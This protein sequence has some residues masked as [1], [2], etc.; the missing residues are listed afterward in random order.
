MSEAKVR[1]NALLQE[2]LAPS[3]DRIVTIL[4]DLGIGG[5]ASAAFCALVRLPQATAGELVSKTGI[6]DSKIY[7]A[8]GELAEKGLIEVQP[9][10]PKSYR[11]VPPKEVEVQLARLIEAEYDRRKAATVRVAAL[12]EP[13]RAATESPSAE[14]AYILKGLTNVVS[15]AKALI[16]SARKDIVLLASDESVFRQLEDELQRVARRRVRLRIAIPEIAI[17]PDLAEIAEVRSIVCPCV[18]LVVD[19]QLVLTVSR[20]SA[21]EAYAITSTDSTLVQLGLDF[22]ESPRCCMA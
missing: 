11:V 1:A 20:T 6:P 14:V 16:G 19:R 3:L 5:K 7:Y 17:P 22:W 4:R 2:S 13:L 15:R 21:G 12:L 18:L 10:K 9:G 8:L